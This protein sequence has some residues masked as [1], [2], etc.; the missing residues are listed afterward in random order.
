MN[1]KQKAI[2]LIGM[3][4][5]LLMGLFPPW[6]Y[7]YKF[8]SEKTIIKPVGFHFLLTPSKLPIIYNASKKIDVLSLKI[9]TLSA[10]LDRLNR[11]IKELQ[12][13]QE[14]IHKTQF[15]KE[16]KKLGI[17]LGNLT[18][19]EQFDLI[20]DLYL[21]R[22]RSDFPKLSEARKSLAQKKAILSNLRA[23]LHKYEGEIKFI[24]P[25]VNYNQLLLQCT[26]VVVVVLGSFFLFKK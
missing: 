21:D 9:Q 6:N 7:V 2:V 22:P 16:L 1:T 8:P 26:L 13:E 11:L 24:E 5:I 25:Q 15:H 14:A 3:T 19:S 10:E 18:Q 17:E 23:E 20:F 12:K 4:L